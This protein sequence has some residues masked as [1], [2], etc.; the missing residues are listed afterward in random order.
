MDLDQIVIGEEELCDLDRLK[1]FR[2]AYL[3]DDNKK[4]EKLDLVGIYMGHS[5]K[6]D[7]EI[8]FDLTKI[9]V[10]DVVNKVRSAKNFIINSNLRGDI[11]LGG[12]QPVYFVIAPQGNTRVIR[13]TS[14]ERYSDVC[15]TYIDL[16]SDFYNALEGDKRKKIFR[17]FIHNQIQDPTSQ[18]ESP[19]EYFMGFVF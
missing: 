2:I 12:Q 11:Y 7:P 17:E 10:D 16:G 9:S 13:E 6:Y 8:Y 5:C 15:L 18:A 19:M 14:R 4:L 3:I 1:E